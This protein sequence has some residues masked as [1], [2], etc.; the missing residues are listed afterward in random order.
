MY[1]LYDAPKDQPFFYAI[2]WNGNPILFFNHKQFGEMVL[3]ALNSGR[4]EPEPKDGSP[5]NWSNVPHG[6]K[7]ATID[8]DGVGCYWT[9]KPEP[10]PVLWNLDGAWHGNFKP[11]HTNFDIRSWRTL[12]WKNPDL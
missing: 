9:D 4:F 7:Y 12:I 11:L 10:G 1:E 8:A 5:V 3:Q 2:Y 6:T